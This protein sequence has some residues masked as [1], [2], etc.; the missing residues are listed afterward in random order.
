M[1]HTVWSYDIGDL[2]D[3]ADYLSDIHADDKEEYEKQALC[4]ELNDSYW[5]D[6]KIN[7][8]V[9]VN[10]IM[11]ADMGLWIGRRNAFRLFSNLN[12]CL[13]VH[14]NGLLTVYVENDELKATEIHHDG[15]NHYAFYRIKDEFVE[16]V[17][18]SGSYEMNM[19]EPL[20]KDV[21][22]VYGWRQ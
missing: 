22:N 20:G 1:R 8:N 21:A 12:E 7:L 11:I 6:E 19:L 14:C 9:P 10:G 3:W 16:Y 18:E 5:D 15:I 4:E 13:N 17:H 2:S